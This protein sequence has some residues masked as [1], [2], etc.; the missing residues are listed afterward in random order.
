MTG[1]IQNDDSFIHI[2]KCTDFLPWVVKGFMQR[3][4]GLVLLQ[5]APKA[6]VSASFSTWAELRNFSRSLALIVPIVVVVLFANHSLAQQ[7]ATVA[8]P[9]ASTSAVRLNAEPSSDS[10]D[11]L[12]ITSNND[13]DALPDDPQS[14]TA[15]VQPRN[16][17]TKR[18]LGIIPNF[19]SVSTDEKLPPM[20]FKQKF[21]GATED[22]FD[23]SSIF[24]PAVLAGYN[25]ERKNTPEFHQGAAGYGRYFWHSFVDQTSE[26]YMVEFIVPVATH[27]DPRYYTLGRGGFVKRA[28]YAL[29]R[30]VVTRNDANNN[31]FNISEVLGSGASS[32]LST[33]YYPSRERTFSNVSQQWGIDIV[34]DAAS[35]AFKEFW[36]DINHAL[37]HGAK[38][39]A[40]PPLK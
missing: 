12:A 1:S 18:I 23:Y 4:S 15:P 32:A 8:Q 19:R 11:A 34:I 14:Q 17:Q 28:S 3:F 29:S 22:S 13:A 33:A 24:I 39:D 25:M 2:R 35:F 38:S 21:V 37:F 9:I 20:T 31:T 36:P 10:T 7:V 16:Q 40:P 6:C 26:N 5:R 27:E 30:V